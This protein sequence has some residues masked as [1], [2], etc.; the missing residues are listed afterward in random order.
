MVGSFPRGSLVF[1]GS[2][3]SPG[4]S[5]PVQ[6]ADRVEPLLVGPSPSKYND[7]IVVRIVTEGAVGSVSWSLTKR[8]D[9]TPDFVDGVVSP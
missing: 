7:S 9:F 2:D 6:N 3:L 8:V 5:L 4:F 1:F